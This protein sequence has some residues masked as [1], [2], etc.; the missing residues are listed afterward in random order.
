M[1]LSDIFDLPGLT[2]KQCAGLKRR[3]KPEMR[4]LRRRHNRLLEAVDGFRR[5]NGHLF[6]YQLAQQ[7]RHSPYVNNANFWKLNALGD[8]KRAAN[9]WFARHN[10]TPKPKY[11]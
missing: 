4:E 10:I 2:P 6:S 9:R 8:L 1:K 11:P 7:I 5:W 3:V